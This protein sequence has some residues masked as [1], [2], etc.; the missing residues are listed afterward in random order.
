MVTGVG[1]PDPIEGEQ[2]WLVNKVLMSGFTF[3][4]LQR[5]CCQFKL[6]KK[7]LQ[8][9]SKDMINDATKWFWWVANWIDF[10][11]SDY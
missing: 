5:W 11:K 2:V 4:V 1:I 6:D 7:Y 3:G 8:D 10:A 9:T